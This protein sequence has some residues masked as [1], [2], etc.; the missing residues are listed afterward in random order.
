MERAC[1]VSACYILADHDDDHSNA[2]DNGT[3]DNHAD[4]RR[5]DAELESVYA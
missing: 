4:T 1:N 2:I 3:I 5:D